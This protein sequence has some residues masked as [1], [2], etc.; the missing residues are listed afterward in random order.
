[1]LAMMP[2]LTSQHPCKSGR[3]KRPAGQAKV[4]LENARQTLATHSSPADVDKLTP[5][6]RLT[7]INSPLTHGPTSQGNNA[8]MSVPSTHFSRSV[9]NAAGNDLG[10]IVLR[11]HKPTNKTNKHKANII[12]HT[13]KTKETHITHTN[14]HTHTSRWSQ[15]TS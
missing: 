7:S 6:P 9:I 2:R 14:T 4:K 1:M 12:T 11:A 8:E 13:H 5:H 10:Q 3:C 15:W